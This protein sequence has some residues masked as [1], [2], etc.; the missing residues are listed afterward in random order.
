MTSTG[1]FGKGLPTPIIDAELPSPKELAGIEAYANSATVPLQ[2]KTFGG[3]SV[4][5]SGGEFCGVILVWTR[6]G[7]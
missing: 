4:F 3:N 1:L 5:N 7:S 2:Y 6:I